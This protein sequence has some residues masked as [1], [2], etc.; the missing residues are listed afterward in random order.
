MLLAGSREMAQIDAYAIDS[1]ETPSTQL[2][3]NAAQCVFRHAAAMLGKVGGRTAV[4]LCGTGKNGGDGLAVARRLKLNGAQVRV[5]IIG[6]RSKA[7]PDTAEMARRL[8]EAGAFAEDFHAQDES[9]RGSLQCADLIVDAMSG[10]GLRGGLRGDALLAAKLVNASGR[11]VLS[12]DM[13]SGVDAD[14]GCVSGEAV[15]A[16]KTVTF[17]LKKPGQLL[18]P[19]R[20]YCGELVCVDIGIAHEALTVCKLDIESMDDAFVRAFF[21]KRRR[22]SHKGDYGRVFA[23]C[24]SEGYTGAAYF[25]AQSAV[26]AGSGLV[27]LGVARCIYPV[28]ASKLNEAM[29]FPL[30]DDEDGKLSIRALEA[31]AAQFDRAD[32][33]LVG[34]G[35]GRS[36]EITELVHRL[37]VDTAA[38]L[39]LDADGI[40]ALEG[41]IHILSRRTGPLVLTPHDGE[42]LRLG[43]VLGPEGRIE[44]ARRFAR[45]H[46][47]VLVL[48]GPS[49]VIADCD[50]RVRINTT[51]TPGMARGGSGDVLAGM[52]ASLIGQGL[53]PFDAAACAAYLHGRAGEICAREKGEYGMTPSDMLEAIPAAIESVCGN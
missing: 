48:K 10:I 8:G 46:R 2:M 21:P 4:I 24:G 11:P 44:T 30:P 17:T 43:G 35:L 36:K 50:G 42:F 12:V 15:K 16:D 29:V 18:M 47:C 41:N 14:T 25:S 26:R 40:N 45:L 6:D 49:T 53:A 23:L 31:A 39:V 13:P 38:P 19:G 22:D 20:E 28:L 9:L 52:I 32:V 5:Y 7:A 34:P 51:G 37:I 33:C 27:G 1:L 3:E